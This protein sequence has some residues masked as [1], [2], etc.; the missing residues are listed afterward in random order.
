MP[1]PEQTPAAAFQGLPYGTNAMVNDQSDALPEA[2]DDPSYDEFN[3]M[4]PPQGDEQFLLSA[5]DRPGEPVTSGMSFGPGPNITPQMVA[6]E[7]PNQF[8]QRVAQTLTS[9]GESSPGLR[10]FIARIEKGF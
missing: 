6:D 5:T 7:T 9:E 3:D 1:R 4:P 10:K 2:E 8:A